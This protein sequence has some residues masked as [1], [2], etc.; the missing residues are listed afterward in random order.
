MII[1]VASGKGGT[2]KT[3]VAA[4]L[5]RAWARPCVAVD[6]D[7]EAPNLHLF[8]NPVWSG[9]V[10]ATLTVPEIANPTA[11]TGCGACTDI[12]AF[13]AILNFGDFPVV[14]PEMCHGCEGCF[15]V[16]RAGVLSRS[17]RVLGDV[18]WGQATLPKQ[19]VP[20]V[21]GRQRIGE[22]MSPPLM[23]EVLRRMGGICTELGQPLD[24]A[25]TIIDAPPGASCPAMEAV[26]PSDVVLLVAE[27][28]PFGLHDLDMAWQAFSGLGK[29]IAVVVN[30]AGGGGVK[31]D[32]ALADWCH[33][34][35]LPIVGRLPYSRAV[36]EAYARRLSVDTVSEE[37]AQEIKKIANELLYVFGAE[38]RTAEEVC[39]AL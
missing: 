22:A 35:D 39:H 19:V 26:Q 6:L 16:C 18:Q 38:Y 10:Q 34:R 11:C 24:L 15:A 37:Y 25:D 36:A 28:T 23:R 17:A 12:C 7:V 21:M 31:G 29:P 2:G 8:L 30:R 4:A 9:Q 14:F 20:L 33:Q 3:S 13:N 5:V 32:A 1:T 27:P